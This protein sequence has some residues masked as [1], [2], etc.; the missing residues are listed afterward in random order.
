[1]SAHL[2][3]HV[4][5][6]EAGMKMLTREQRICICSKAPSTKTSMKDAFSTNLRYDVNSKAHQLPT[7]LLSSGKTLFKAP[8]IGNRC[9]KES[10]LTHF[11]I[12]QRS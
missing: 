3:I 11:L 6:G 12:S 4:C 1:M 7:L 5:C 2:N 10:G 8:L 9:L